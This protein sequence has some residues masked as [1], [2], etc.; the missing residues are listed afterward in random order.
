MAAEIDGSLYDFPFAGPARAVAAAV[1]ESI[2]F[3]KRSLQDRFSGLGDKNVIARFN[4]DLMRHWMIDE[5][6]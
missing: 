1:R 5:A 6:N 4:G 3:A 2:T